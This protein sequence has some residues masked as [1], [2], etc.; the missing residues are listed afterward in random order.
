MQLLIALILV[1]SQY[2]SGFLGPVVTIVVV[3]KG[4]QGYIP[5]QRI[6]ADHED[7]TTESISLLITYG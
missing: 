4:K 5:N 3:C 1:D 6:K 2:K 7:G